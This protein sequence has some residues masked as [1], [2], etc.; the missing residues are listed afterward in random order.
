MIDPIALTQALIRC[1][2]VTP[3]DAGALQALIDALTPLGFECHALPF[4]NIQNL[5]AR[6]GTGKPHLCFLGH[7]DVVPVGDAAAWTHLPFAAVIEGEKLYGRG[8]SDMKGGIACFIA[9]LSEPPPPNLP[10]QGG[11]RTKEGG[12]SISLLITGDEEGESI[13]GTVKVLE[14]MA[15]QNHI[16]DLFV[17]GEPTNPDALGDEIKIGRRGNMVGRLGV[18]GKQ[19]HTAYPHRADNPLPRLVKLLDALATY[20]FDQGNDFFPPTNLQLTSIDVGNT[21]PNIIPAKGKAIF[22]VRFN[23]FWNART[24]E[25][26]LREILDAVAVPYTLETSCTAESFITKPNAYSAMMSDAV[27]KITGRKPAL[28]TSGGTSDARFAVKYAPVVECGAVNR[29]IHQVN[30]FA[31]LDDLHR[32]TDIYRVFL[33]SFFAKG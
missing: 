3:E 7:T 23:D 15:A 6:R 20:E 26:K 12:G 31:M 24:L 13:N 2:S 28:T 33:Q 14:W 29:T 5:F 25:A 21:A 18:S 11:G 9:A 1:P 10:P 19:G 16:P 4:G 32:L 17:V 22:N 27:E 8:A 30:E